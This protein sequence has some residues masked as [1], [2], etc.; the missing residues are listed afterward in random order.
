M[1]RAMT[2]EASAGIHWQ[3]TKEQ[4]W[5][6]A[7]QLA[8]DILPSINA[9]LEVPVFRESIYNRYIKRV[10]DIVFVIPLLVIT[11]PINLIIAICTLFDVGKPIFFRQERAGRNGL[12]FTIIKFRNMRNDKDTN[13]ELLPPEQRVTR[14]G[15][16]FRRTSLDELLTLFAVLAGKMSI[17]GPRP[18][19]PEYVHRYSNSHLLRLAVRPGLECP[20]RGGFGEIRSW[21]EQFENDI[22]YVANVSFLT[23]IRMVFHFVRFLVHPSISH[24]REWASRGTFMGYNLDGD[25]ISMTDV[26]QAYAKDVL[27]KLDTKHG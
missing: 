13:G 5:A 18:L 22:W 4:R 17:I 23:D 12:P 26:P 16:F 8:R 25:V 9:S 19:P 14:I 20:P 27:R 1:A 3:L 6:I 11:A 15:R 7:D 10:L 24:A 21:Q 2:A